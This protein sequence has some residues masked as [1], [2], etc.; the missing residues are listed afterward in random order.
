MI[1]IM[2]GTVLRIVIAIKLE[3]KGK[4][5]YKLSEIDKR[6]QVSRNCQR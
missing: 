6:K 3:R 2:A 5:I 1:A 4:G